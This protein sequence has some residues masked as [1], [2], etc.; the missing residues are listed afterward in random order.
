MKGFS[1]LKN[2]KGI[3]LESA[4]IFMVSIFT[5]CFLLSSLTLLGHSQAKINNIYIENNLECDQLGEQFISYVNAVTIQQCST[6]VIAFDEGTKQIT[7]TCASVGASIYYTTNGDNPEIKE[8]QRYGDPIKIEDNCTIKA[9]AVCNGY[10]PSA[11]VTGTV[12]KK[13]DG[14]DIT[15]DP[16]ETQSE[17]EIPATNATESLYNYFSTNYLSYNPQSVATGLKI[18]HGG[19]VYTVIEQ[20]T[21]VI[22]NAINFKFIL[23]SGETTVMEI[24]CVKTAESLENQFVTIEEWK[25]Y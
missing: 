6:P 9:I 18:Q 2:K 20:R 8:E 13:D 11:T 17:S 22:P 5:F 7:I 3:A 15:C 25:K 4:I 12:Q 16:A 14:F 23:K 21:T 10:L 24:S 1:R 19:R